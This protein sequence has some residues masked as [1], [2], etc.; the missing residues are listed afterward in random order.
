M[1]VSETTPSAAATVITPTTW[2][3]E[4]EPS[5][6]KATDVNA[7]SESS[8]EEQ[9][10]HLKSA[11]PLSKSP[12]CPKPLQLPSEC[13]SP[14]LS[15]LANKTNIRPMQTS[16]ISISPTDWLPLSKDA[17]VSTSPVVQ[18]TS[19]ENPPL[20]LE[21]ENMESEH[22]ASDLRPK[23]MK[24]KNLPLPV[25]SSFSSNLPSLRD[26]NQSESNTQSPILMKYKNLSLPV[27]S[28]FS[29][30][31]PSLRD[32]NQSESNTQSPKVLKYKD[33]SLP[34]SSSFSSD[35]P[36]LR[37]QN[38]SE[39]NTQLPKVMKYKDLSLPVSSSFSS[40]LPS[41]RDQN[42]SE[43]NTQSPKVLK[44]KNLPLP[45]SSSFSSDPPSLRDQNQ[46]ESNTPSAIVPNK[47]PLPDSRMA[48]HSAPSVVRPPVTLPSP[49]TKSVISVIASTATSVISRVCNPPEPEN[50][51]NMS[52]G[53]PCVDM[54]LP[55]SSYRPSK[56]DTGSYHGQS[57]GDEGGV[58]PVSLLRAP[59]LVWDP[60]LV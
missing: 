43:S 44:Y 5:V 15:P 36:S 31:T 41:L 54:T 11:Y 38:Q 19:K 16:R 33:L 21:S 3:P 46:S 40:E 48:A 4:P 12:I 42:Q 53:N 47:S 56:D 13:I 24:Y 30:D 7:E 35:L 8:S 10:Q 39:S 55:K 25:S 2:K 49:E 9:I 17:G 14:S 29:S 22:G 32:Q 1:I 52:I 20:P 60:A 34:V 59:P 50:K 23:L 57:V 58:L 51:V 26:Q 18:L 6:V 28:S 45:V 27:S 37:D